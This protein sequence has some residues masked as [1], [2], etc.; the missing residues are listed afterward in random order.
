MKKFQHAMV[1]PKFESL[2]LPMLISIPC[3][4]HSKARSMLQSLSNSVLRV[5]CLEPMF[6]CDVH[7][8]REN[9]NVNC[10]REILQHKIHQ[11]SANTSNTVPWRRSSDQ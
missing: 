9:V 6:T 7:M 4:Q 3:K 5:S 8:S 10:Q 1:V 11:Q 2:R